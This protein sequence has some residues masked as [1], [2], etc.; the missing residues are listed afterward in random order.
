[1]DRM[2]VVC[3]NGSA[4][5]HTPG[6]PSDCPAQEESLLFLNYITTNPTV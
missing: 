5:K 2:G 4:S 3:D 1:M 6:N